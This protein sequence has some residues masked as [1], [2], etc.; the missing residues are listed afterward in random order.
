MRPGAGHRFPVF[1]PDGTHFL[2]HLA[3]D[4]ADAAGIYVGTLDGSPGA[5][6]LSGSSNALYMAPSPGNRTGHLLFRRE[7]TLLA[8]PFDAV[9]LTSPGE[10]L[11]VAERV[12]SSHN[13]GFGAFSASSNGTIAY[14]TASGVLRELVW[15][16]RSGTRLGAVTK[17]GRFGERPAISPD[18]RTVAIT[19]P[20]AAGVDIWLQDLGRDVLSRFTLGA[21]TARSPVWSPDG[22]RLAYAFQPASAYSYEIYIKPVTGSAPEKLLGGGV[23]AY[24]TDWSSDGRWIVYHQQG[25]ATGMDLWL[26]P[27]DGDRKPTPFL[28]TPAHEMN[29]RF[30]PHSSGGPRWM[31]YQS[32][33]TGRNEIYVQSIPAGMTYQIST[34]GGTKPTWRSDGAELFYESNRKL[35]AV[36]TT[37]GTGVAFGPSRELFANADTDGY[38]VAADGQRFLLNVPVDTR[39]VTAAPVTVVVGWTAASKR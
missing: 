16:N 14:R 2:Y 18:Q 11:P 35:M 17:P 31:A 8:Q 12:G 32:D 3:D 21:G 15:T 4:N 20:A 27:L 25:D 30:A 26:M 24:P 13:D 10:A 29:G 1:L 37:L 34:G 7:T 9:T 6:I 23:N 36:P 19:A 22:T 38:E 28:H 33:E 39:R 5:R